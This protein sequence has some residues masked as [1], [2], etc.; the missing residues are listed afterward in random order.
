[1]RRYLAR[2]KEY[3]I[4]FLMKSMRFVV[5]GFEDMKVT[6]SSI[7]GGGGGVEQAGEGGVGGH[8][9]GLPILPE[10][11]GSLLSFSNTQKSL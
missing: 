5:D 10:G 9:G 6:C 3:I 11:E 1:M 4:N 8:D 2:P 7:G